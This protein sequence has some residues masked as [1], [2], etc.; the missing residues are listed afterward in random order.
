MAITPELF[1]EK[2]L[3]EHRS[4]EY[5]DAGVEY[6]IH[7]TE[8]NYPVLF[9]SVH[10]AI[11]MGVQSNY[12]NFLVLNREI[13]YKYFKLK[14][15]KGGYREIMSPMEDLKWMQRWI[16][17]NILKDTYLT[18]AAKGFRPKI[19]IADNA[20]PH[21]NKKV[22]LKVDLLKFY[23]TITEKRVFGLFKHMG[24]IPNLAVDLAKL[25]TAKHRKAYWE[26]MNADEKV[27][28]NELY[29]NKPAILPQGAPTSPMIANLIANRMD[30]RF[31]GLSKKYNFKYTRYADDLT[32]SADDNKDIPPI[33]AIKAI[34][35]KE[36]FYMNPKKIVYMKRG[37]KQFVTGLTVTNGV[38]VPK[39]L[40]KEIFMHLHFTKR[41]GPITHVQNWSRKRNLPNPKVAFQDWLSGSIAFIYSIE[42][43]TGKKMLDI[44]NK[45]DWSLALEE[46]DNT[47]L[48]Q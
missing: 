11:E 20:K 47:N 3:K 38:H 44:F 28:L 22:I 31:L 16:L 10:L 36:G 30:K 12:L 37:M 4:Q 24:Y 32:F 15:S 13:R 14:K 17:L 40:R 1:I 46:N 34:I 8:R 19:S 29:T 2:A 42:P 26:D 35:E 18:D 41:F 7:L 9:S 21:Q 23:D 48:H 25:T 39:K 45:I 33:E 6:I 43:E 5:I 27:L